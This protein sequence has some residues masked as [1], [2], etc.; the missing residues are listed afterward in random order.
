MSQVIEITGVLAI[1]SMFTGH[2]ARALGLPM[3]FPIGG[4]H[5]FPA[6][7][8][9]R[10]RHAR[11]FRPSN[12]QSEGCL[13]QALLDQALDLG[14]AEASASSAPGRPPRARAPA[15]MARRHA[16][17]TPP[18]GLRFFGPIGG[19][20]LGGFIKHIEIGRGL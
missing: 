1:V 12:H 2:Q 6:V 3:C 5:E 9:A 16:G 7:G 15:P 20:R 10:V 4:K 19:G 8:M 14:E 17:S 13:D 11:A 18:V